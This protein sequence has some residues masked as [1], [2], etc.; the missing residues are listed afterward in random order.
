MM[1]SSARHFQAFKAA[2]QFMTCLPVGHS[3]DAPDDVRSE[4]LF[5]YPIVGAMIGI[6]LI[7]VDWLVSPLSHF[8][9]AAL[10]VTIW[11]IITGALHLD[12][13]ADFADAWVGGLGSRERTLEIMHDPRCGPIAVVALTLTLIL[14]IAALTAFHDWVLLLLVPMIARLMIIPAFHSLPYARQSGVGGEIQTALSSQSPRKSKIIVATGAVLPL[15]FV[16]PGLWILLVVAAMAT[17]WLWRFV[18]NKR[19]QGFTGDCIGLLVEV[20]ELVMLLVFATF[21][22]TT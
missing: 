11:V 18:M 5:W 8:L 13:L 19:L 9:Q 10:L 17:F 21:A 15:V 2:V 22:L 20:S 16:S 14:K 1:F 7:L 4:M 3:V 12:G 6:I